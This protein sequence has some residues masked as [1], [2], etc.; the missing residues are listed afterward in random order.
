MAASASARDSPKVMIEKL[1]DSIRDF[2]KV[3]DALRLLVKKFQIPPGV[4]VFSIAKLLIVSLLFLAARSIVSGRTSTFGQSFIL[5][6]LALLLFFLVGLSV[7]WRHRRDDS[8]DDDAANR[9]AGFVF[10][11]WTVSI[12]I[13]VVIDVPLVAMTRRPL[14]AFL[15]AEWPFYAFGLQLP[16]TA[17]EV[18]R[19]LLVSLLAWSAIAIR[20]NLRHDDFRISCA[21][22]SPEFPVF[23]GI[24]SVLLYVF[25]FAAY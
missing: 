15:F 3:L 8:T 5:T 22:R 17:I 18:A 6:A 16:P 4:D 13:V 9:I 11:L 21:F 20:T 2:F 1:R 14:G 12:I 10:L 19:A 23:V 25:V 24:N 7:R